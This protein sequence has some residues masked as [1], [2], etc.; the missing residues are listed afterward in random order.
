MQISGQASAKS[1]FGGDNNSYQTCR[2]S[3]LLFRRGEGGTRGRPGYSLNKT[4]APDK[5]T[6]LTNKHNL[7]DRQTNKQTQPANQGILVTGPDED[8]TDVKETKAVEG[9]EE[10][11]L[12]CGQHSRKAFSFSYFGASLHP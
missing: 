4:R 12:V 5:Q 8:S 9:D 6:K 2:P 7:T 11:C 1:T 10:S 3:S